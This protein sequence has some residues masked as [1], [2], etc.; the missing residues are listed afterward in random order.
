M[1]N[2]RTS[3]HRGVAR[4]EQRETQSGESSNSLRTHSGYD[5]FERT[6]RRPVAQ[7]RRR[8][9]LWFG[10]LLDNLRHGS[11]NNLTNG[12]LQHALLEHDLYHLND[13]SHH[14]RNTNTGPPEKP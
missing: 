4:H 11:V 1:S 8:S 9:A 10:A 6:S 13:L 3:V 5:S 7:E 12:S 2:V 14:V